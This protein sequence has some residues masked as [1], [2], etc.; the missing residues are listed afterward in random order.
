MIEFSCVYCGRSM[1][2]EDDLVRKTIDCPGCG[3]TVRVLP[4][5]P[6]RPRRIPAAPTPERTRKAAE[7]WSRMSNDEIRE[8]VLTPALPESEKRLRNLKRIFAPWLPRYDDLTLFTFSL[9]FLLLL[10]VEDDLRQAITGLLLP[11]GADPTAT[12]LLLVLGGALYSLVNVFVPR[13]KLPFE[14]TPMLLF[15]LMVTV[16]TGFSAGRPM[17]SGGYGLLALFPL[18]N[19]LN[20]VILLFLT[21]SRILDEDCLTGERATLRRIILAIVSIVLLVLICHYHYRLAAPTT[22]SIAVAYT[23][24]LQNAVGRF[25][26]GWLSPIVSRGR[27]LPRCSRSLPR[28]PA[29]RSRSA[30]S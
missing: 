18:W 22:F 10:A 19:L 12:W 25:L 29:G 26:G 21:V 20:G 30:A 2:V 3:H 13:K 15:A 28:P 5:K 1:R 14:K 7:R 27:C 17:L 11:R 4:S 16:G 9:A 23:M 8:A 6:A 24:S